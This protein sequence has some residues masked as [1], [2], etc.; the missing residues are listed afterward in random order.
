MK[1]SAEEMNVLSAVVPAGGSG[2]EMPLASIAPF[3]LLLACIALLPLFAPHFWESNR[4]KAIVGALLAVP[5]AAWL[6]GAHG[7]RGWAELEHALL[8]YFS[9]MALLGAL[10]F[11]SGGIHVRGSLAGTPLA[12]T[13]LLAIGAVLANLIGTTG[14][15]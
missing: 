1:E 12:N 4:N 6:V 3:A 2:V 8:D 13:L 14:A 15:S 9:F 7:A 10:Y 5:F 11:I